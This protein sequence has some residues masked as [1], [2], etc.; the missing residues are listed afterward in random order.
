MGRDRRAEAV[1]A[2]ILGA[3]LTLSG[4]A[5]AVLEENAMPGSSDMVG[6]LPEET[7]TAIPSC[8]Y[9]PASGFCPPY[10]Q[11]FCAPAY[12][13]PGL[14]E[15]LP[16][17][18]AA[19]RE[20]GEPAFPVFE[21]YEGRSPPNA[22]VRERIQTPFPLLRE[23]VRLDPR[24]ER[25]LTVPRPGEQPKEEPQPSP[26]AP[27]QEETP[28][29][30]PTQQPWDLPGDLLTEPMPWI[31]PKLP[32]PGGRPEPPQIEAPVEQSESSDN[33][34]PEQPSS[35]ETERSSAAT[36]KPPLDLP[37]MDLPGYHGDLNAPRTPWSRSGV[38]LNPLEIGLPTT[39]DSVSTMEF[40]TICNDGWT[41]S[42]LLGLLAKPDRSL[43]YFIEPADDEGHIT[44][45]QSPK[46]EPLRLWLYFTWFGIAKELLSSEERSGSFA[47]SALTYGE[48][49]VG[50]NVFAD[51]GERIG[52]QPVDLDVG[53]T[54]C[55]T[56][57]VY[58]T[59]DAEMAVDYASA[60][61]WIDREGQL[62]L[63][64]E[65]YSETGDLVRTMDVEA[66]GF[67]WDTLVANDIYVQDLVNGCSTRI[68]FLDGW[69]AVGGIPD[70]VFDPENLDDFDPISMGFWDSE[71]HLGDGSSTA[72]D[73][74]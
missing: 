60:L 26:R 62:A 41:G 70:E 9:H 16:R 11:P 63:K 33:S 20:E 61:F 42:N 29:R 64:A 51:M 3:L 43:I 65:Y 69:P 72:T 24:L 8:S 35:S 21:R 7:L 46:G 28:T 44:L 23:L 27:G 17:R 45:A 13:P 71:G 48:V 32:E 53:G 10:F 34:T 73:E 49:I 30:T 57:I 54:I 36:E 40:E 1:V 14:Y 2:L 31:Q 50:R 68:R 22:V 66:L 25:N 6:I 58:L 52:D 19:C 47:G 15:C 37:P 59:A 39:G 55:S 18:C 12:L 67:F 56:D 4:V 74:P 5:V 38:R